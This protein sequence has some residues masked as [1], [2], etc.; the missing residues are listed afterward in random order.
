MLDGLLPK[1]DGENWIRALGGLYPC[2]TGKLLK[3][4][5]VARNLHASLVAW[6]N[7]QNA[8]VPRNGALLPHGSEKRRPLWLFRP[9]LEP[10]FVSAND[11][12]PA[13]RIIA[14]QCDCIFR[15]TVEPG[16]VLVGMQDD[17]HPVVDVEQF[18]SRVDH[19]AGVAIA[20][21]IR[22]APQSR[23]SRS[24]LVLH[25]D[26]RPRHLAL[27]SLSLREG[28]ERDEAAV[29]RRR[30]P[31]LPERRQQLV[32][33]CVVDWLR[34]AGGLHALEAHRETPG[35]GL[36][37]AGAFMFADDNTG[38]AGIDFFGHIIPAVGSGA[39]QVRCLGRTIECQGCGETTKL[40]DH[41]PIAAVQRLIDE[42]GDGG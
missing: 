34:L 7:H 10:A 9:G 3:I 13:R 8:K 25:A 5:G 37:D 18:L 22:R 6:T 42:A 4:Y 31:I 20:P 15:W 17:R 33:A 30:E 29:C 32:V 19:D 21:F 14:H 39:E 16:V 38:I 27:R 36:N 40:E 2:D 28:G 11:D 12:K 41:T 23:P 35:H 24:R 1:P 26:P